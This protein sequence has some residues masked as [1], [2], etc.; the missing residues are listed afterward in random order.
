MDVVSKSL[1]ENA[2]SDLDAIDAILAYASAG[3]ARSKPT[4]AQLNEIVAKLGNAR[5][6]LKAALGQ[7]TGEP[8]FDAA[9]QKAREPLAIHSGTIGNA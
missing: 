7:P 6:F 2:K 9:I 5:T 4:I 3:G 1:V 8:T